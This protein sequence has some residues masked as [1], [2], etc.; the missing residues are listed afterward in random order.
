MGFF[1]RKITSVWTEK[2]TANRVISVISLASGA[3]RPRAGQSVKQDAVGGQ[4]PGGQQDILGQVLGDLSAPVKDQI[5]VE[6][7]VEAGAD[8]PGGDVAAH[9]PPGQGAGAPCKQQ[10]Q[11]VVQ[12]KAGQRTGCEFQRCFTV[13]QCI[14]HKNSSFC[15][16][17][18]GPP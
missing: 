2:L 4:N 13:G 16:Q 14:F 5:F 11:Q 10:E 7:V 18:T 8:Q 17:Y 9:K 3:A 6:R 15:S 1:F 12:Q